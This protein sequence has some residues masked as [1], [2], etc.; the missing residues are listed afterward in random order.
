LIYIPAGCAHGFLTLE[1]NTE[2]N[3]LVNALFNPT[4]ERGIRYN[5][6]AFNI[7]WPSEITVISEKDNSFLNYKI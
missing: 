7:Q 3:Y 6:P 4:L 2:V 5:D 1:N